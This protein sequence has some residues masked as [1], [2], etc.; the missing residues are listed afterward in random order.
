PELALLLDEF[1]DEAG[2]AGLVRRAEAGAGIAMKIIVKQIAMSIL[3]AVG[4]IAGRAGK[5]ALVF[6]VAQ[7]KLDQSIG[8]LVRDFI[9]MHEPAGSGWAFN[10][11]IVAVVMVKLLERLDEQV[12]NRKPH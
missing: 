9:Q 1:R 10:F 6:F 4:P 7:K 2:P 3:R 8:K 5:C 11:E 12:I